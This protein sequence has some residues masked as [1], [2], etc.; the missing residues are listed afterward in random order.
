MVV[1]LSTWNNPLWARGTEAL[2]DGLDIFG[3]AECGTAI[4]IQG[5]P[6]SVLNASV[7]KFFKMA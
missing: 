2:L 1:T 6:P 3:C 4:G 7:A 5:P